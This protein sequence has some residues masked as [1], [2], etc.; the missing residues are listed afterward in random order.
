ME[1]QG[2]AVPILSL[3]LDESC[4]VV[5]P[6]AARVKVVRGVVAIVETVT[7]GLNA[8][9]SAKIDCGSQQQRA[10]AHKHGAD[11]GNNL[12]TD[13]SIRVMLDLKSESGS[14]SSTKACCPQLPTIIP[15]R[16]CMNG[17]INTNVVARRWYRASSHIIAYEESSDTAVRHARLGFPLRMK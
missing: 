12:L 14:C 1:G 4:R 10:D 5:S 13:T 16:I 6:M 7:V 9:I 11:A 2:A 15:M 3:R 8:W 17:M